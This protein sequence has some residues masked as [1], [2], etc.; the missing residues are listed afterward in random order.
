MAVEQLKLLIGWRRISTV[1][2]GWRKR[3]FWGQ[4][5]H[6]SPLPCVIF[7]SHIFFLKKRVNIAC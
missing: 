1:L 2:P 6:N 4:L 7:F 5:P 3:E